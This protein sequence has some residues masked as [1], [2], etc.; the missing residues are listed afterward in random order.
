MNPNVWTERTVDPWLRNRR[1]VASIS[2]RLVTSAP[3]SPNVPRFFWMMKLVATA[4]LSSPCFQPGPAP[5][6]AWAL[7]STTQS[8]CSFAIALTALMSALRP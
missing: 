7:S 8:L 6:I 4:S 3:P 1:T 2:S 5:S